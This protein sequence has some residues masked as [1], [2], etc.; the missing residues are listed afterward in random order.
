MIQ[1]GQSYCES[2]AMDDNAFEKKKRDGK[3]K[4]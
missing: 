1:S 3:D 2:I 4:N